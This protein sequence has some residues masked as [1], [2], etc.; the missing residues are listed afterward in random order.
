VGTPSRLGHVT[1]WAAYLEGLY[2]VAEEASLSNAARVQGHK[3]NA[4]LVMVPLVHLQHCQ[5]VAE[6]QQKL[7]SHSSQ[8]CTHHMHA[9]RLLLARV[10]FRLVTAT[11][12]SS[13]MQQNIRSSLASSRIQCGPVAGINQRTRIASTCMVVRRGLKQNMTQHAPCHPCT[14]WEPP[15]HHR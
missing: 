5:H 13:N 10:G 14:P 8:A 1:A 11:G 6:L 12:G 9:H 3:R 2:V 7:S 4:C 15:I